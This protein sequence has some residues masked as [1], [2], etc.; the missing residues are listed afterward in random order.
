M[1]SLA[2]GTVSVLTRG[3]DACGSGA[4]RLDWVAA[5]LED[6]RSA[7]M[8]A[9]DHSRDSVGPAHR[10]HELAA[11]YASARLARELVHRAAAEHDTEPLGDSLALIASELVANALQHGLG[12][13]PGG[14]IGTPAGNAAPI[15]IGLVFACAQ[16]VCAV[17]DPSADVPLRMV[18]DD[19]TGSGRG[20]QLISSLSDLWGWTVLSE[21]GHPAGK[22]VWAMLSG[23]APVRGRAPVAHGLSPGACGPR[24]TGS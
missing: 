6:L 8:L 5:V 4:H 19:L 21:G 13:D 3:R 1:P 2:G 17:R 11:D 16:V 22:A 10:V 15:E 24:P 9:D 20:V 14:A 23:A 12:L 18:S 7:G